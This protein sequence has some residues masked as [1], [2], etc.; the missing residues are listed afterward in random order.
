MTGY[1]TIDLAVIAT[2]KGAF[3][4][5]TKP[6]NIGE[7]INLCTRALSQSR[8]ETENAQLRSVIKKQYC[9]DQIIGQSRPILD[10]LEM[11]K[12]IAGSSSTVLLNGESGTGKELVARSIHFNSEQNKGPFIPVHCG[13]I[14]KTFWKVNFSAM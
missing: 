7:I 10:L 3:H 11:V 1:G 6:F 5:I 2:K 8:L 13:A 14:P 9:F 4:F 12:K